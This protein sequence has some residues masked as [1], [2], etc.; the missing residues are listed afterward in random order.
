MLL[1]NPSEEM[2]FSIFC[3]IPPRRATDIPISDSRDVLDLLLIRYY[4]VMNILLTGDL[5][6]RR[7]GPH[8]T[9]WVP[10]ATPMLNRCWTDRNR[11]KECLFF[12]FGSALRV[13]RRYWRSSSQSSAFAW[14]CERC[15]K[16]FSRYWQYFAPVHWYFHRKA[17]SSRYRQVVPFLFALFLRQYWN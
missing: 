13:V 14:Q 2:I 7:T 6:C 4:Y 15:S 16:L 11:P 8:R 10:Q 1:W 9:V 5:D 3:L 12:S 17:W